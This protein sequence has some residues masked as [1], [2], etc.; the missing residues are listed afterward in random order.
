MSRQDKKTG[1]WS[2]GNVSASMKSLRRGYRW[3][4]YRGRDRILRELGFEAYADY[5]ASEL[6]AT[7]RKRVLGKEKWTCKRCG[8]KG[9]QVHHIQ[10]TKENLSGRS[11]SRMVCLCA[12]CHEKSERLPD[13]T[14]TTLAEANKIIEQGVL[15]IELDALENL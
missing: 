3:D 5:L 7:I 1:V 9:T 14:K 2:R 12:H 15:D 13:G 6:W 10:Y 4:A 11:L 8:R